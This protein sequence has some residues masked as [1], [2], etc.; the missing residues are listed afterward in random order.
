MKASKLTERREKKRNL[1]GMLKSLR[2]KRG[3]KPAAALVSARCSKEKKRGKKASRTPPDAAD[4]A[5]EIASAPAPAPD[6]ASLSATNPAPAL[7]SASCSK[8]KKRGKKASPPDAADVAS[9]IAS[10]PAPAPDF[11]SLSA[12]NPAPALVS[13]RCSKGKKRGKKASPPDAA[14]V[15]PEIASAP[16]PAPDFASLSATNPAPALVSASCS[17]EKKRGKKASPPDAADVAS[18]IASAP[19]PA[20]ASAVDGQHQRGLRESDEIF[21]DSCKY[22]GQLIYDAI[23]EATSSPAKKPSVKRLGIFPPAATPAPATAAPDKR[24]KEA[25][26][27]TCHVKLGLGHCV[28]C[29]DHKD[30]PPP[31]LGKRRRVERG[32]FAHSDDVSSHLYMMRMFCGFFFQH[33]LVK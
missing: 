31:L 3:I 11:A 15:A 26:C 23:S 21:S 4:V 33:F 22:V 16:A 19:A 29:V 5:P 28:K 12:T 6:F 17:K 18:D 9:D 8:G 10:V 30:N 20:P 24:Q 13:A 14:V 27:R 7:V 25:S 32:P 1:V 2:K